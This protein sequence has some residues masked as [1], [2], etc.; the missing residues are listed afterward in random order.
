[1][2]ILI[3]HYYKTSKHQIE[4]V[5][6][7]IINVQLT[8]RKNLN[9]FTKKREKHNLIWKRVINMKYFSFIF[10]NKIKTSNL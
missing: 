2:I 7:I 6:E 10:N 9:Y 4:R 3:K 1:M 8:I 5:I